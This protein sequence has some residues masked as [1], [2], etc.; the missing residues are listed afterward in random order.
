MEGI[1]YV[2]PTPVIAHFLA[3]VARHGGFTGFPA[4]GLEWQPLE[5]PALRASLG[6]GPGATG[7]LATIT[8]P[9]TAISVSAGVLTIT[10]PIGNNASASG[11]AAKAE[12]RN[13]NGVTIASGLT[14]GTTGTDVIINS[15]AISSG[16]YVQM[17]TSTITHG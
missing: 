15:T 8:I 4:L 2:I 16:Q 17:N 3:D 7:V 6:M 1:G 5:A 13:G 14:V 10:G 11:T 9:T 12:L